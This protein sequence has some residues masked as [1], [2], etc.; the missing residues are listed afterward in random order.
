MLVTVRQRF[1]RVTKSS[2]A[3]YLWAGI[4]GA[5]AMFGAQVL[6]L[7]IVAEIDPPALWGNEFTLATALRTGVHMLIIGFAG[8]IFRTWRLRARKG[9]P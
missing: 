2:F 8:N 6:F 9:N 4:I 1:A 5:L 3:V 7:L